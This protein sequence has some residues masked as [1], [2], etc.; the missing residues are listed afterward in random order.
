MFKKLILLTFIFSV[1][2]C[3]SQKKVSISF[4]IENISS[5]KSYLTKNNVLIDTLDLYSLK[6][7]SSFAKFNNLDLLQVPE[8]LFFNSNGYLVK[9]RFNNNECSKV[10]NDIKKIDNLSFDKKNTID[11]LLSDLSSFYN[12]KVEE[13]TIYVVINWAKFVDDF[14]KQSF[15]WYNELKNSSNEIKVKCIFLNLDVQENWNINEEQKKAL[16][17]K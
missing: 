4:E 11:Q 16:N 7:F 15:E 3:A 5:L 8:I 13:N 2:S 17:I 12:N 14:N 6:N 1:F 9:N 10:I